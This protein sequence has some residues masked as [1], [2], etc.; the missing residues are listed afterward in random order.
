MCNEHDSTNIVNAIPFDSL[1]KQNQ[2]EKLVIKPLRYGK[3]IWKGRAE[4]RRE[5]RTNGRRELRE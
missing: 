1:I 3:K 2:K 4:E 5:L